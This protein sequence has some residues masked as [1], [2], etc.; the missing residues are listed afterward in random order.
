MSKVVPTKI[1]RFRQVTD[2]DRKWFLFECPTCGEWLPMKEEHLNGSAPIDH[3]S[4]PDGDRVR[5][6]CAFSGKHK[7]GIELVTTMQ[8]RVLMD[9]SPCDDITALEGRAG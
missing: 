1:G 7:L 8:V 5:M 2:G 3:L 9:E 4:R 6:T